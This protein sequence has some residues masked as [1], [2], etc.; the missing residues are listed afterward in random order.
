MEEELSCLSCGKAI[1]E[2]DDIFCSDCNDL[3]ENKR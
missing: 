2:D 3:I 1:N